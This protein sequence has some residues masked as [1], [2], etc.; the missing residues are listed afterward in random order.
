MLIKTMQELFALR[1]PTQLVL[2]TLSVPEKT[3]LGSFNGTPS[4]INGPLDV[5]T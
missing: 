4:S 3:E 1:I 5:G 2:K